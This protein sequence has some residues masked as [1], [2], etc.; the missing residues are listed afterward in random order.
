MLLCRRELRGGR[1]ARLVGGLVLLRVQQ[2]DRDR[3]W[4]AWPAVDRACA[5]AT[6]RRRRSYASCRR[7]AAPGRRAARRPRPSGCPGRCGAGSRPARPPPRATSRR[8]RSSCF[9]AAT[10]ASALVSCDCAC[11]TES[12]S[13][14]RCAA[15]SPASVCAS[16]ACAEARP[17]SACRTAIRAAARVDARRAPA[18]RARAARGG[19][20]PRSARRRPG[21]RARARARARGCRSPRPWREHDA[22]LHGC[23]AGHG[24]RRRGRAADV[25]VGDD[26]EARDERGEQDDVRPGVA[27]ERRAPGVWAL[28][29][30]VDTVGR[31]SAGAGTES[32]SRSSRAILRGG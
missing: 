18:R 17:A 25:Q 5:A 13:C 29:E 24:R 2:P 1:V 23:G 16:W 26:A 12:A 3:C 8:A 27:A 7:R 14:R 11:E 22:A 19:R 30:S 21:S 32:R 31:P 20:R 28:P 6:W 9:C 10:D 15:V 4:L